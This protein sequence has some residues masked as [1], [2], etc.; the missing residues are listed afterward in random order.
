MNQQ[1]RIPTPSMCKPA[2]PIRT[3]AR[4]RTAILAIMMSALA[5]WMGRDLKLYPCEHAFHH[6]IDSPVLAIEL[7]STRAEVETVLVPRCASYDEIYSQE[8]QKAAAYVEARKAAHSALLRDTIADC[9]F[10]PLYTLFIWSFG[11]LFAVDN[12][13]PRIFLRRTL[14]LATIATAI[15][16]YI[17]NIGIFRSLALGPSD[18]LAEWTSWPSRFKWAMFA[19]SLLLTFVILLRSRN[20]MYSLATRRLFALGYLTIGM[21]LAMGVWRPTLIGLGLQIYAVIVLLQISAL[22]GPYIELLFPPDTPTY[23][24]DFCQRRKKESVDLAVHE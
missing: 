6:Q 5:A 22:L 23:E 19:V 8:A 4:F 2:P 11:S 17:E 9:F 16:D 13:K 12:P 10:I 18:I 21:L 15:L 7:A 20:P 3:F 24:D 14:A 1:A